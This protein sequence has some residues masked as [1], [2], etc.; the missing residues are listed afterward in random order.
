[1][2]SG[3]RFSAPTVNDRTY[4]V[5]I[6]SLLNRGFI[7]NRKG[8]CYNLL[9]TDEYEESLAFILIRLDMASL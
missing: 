1:M 4:Q 6:H 5:I 9:T 7:I 3:G 8:Y 2:L